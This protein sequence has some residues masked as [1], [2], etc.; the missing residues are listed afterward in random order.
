MVVKTL[1]GAKAVAEAVKNCQPDVV[2]C[3]PITPSTHIAEEMNHYYANGDT[4]TFIAVES[5]FSAISALIGGAA[6]G[7]RT[8]TATSSQGLLLMH[9]ALFNAAGMRLPIVMVVANRAVSAPL[10]IWND[11]QDSMSQRDT[12]WIQLYCKNNQE[13]VDSVI[14]AFEIAETTLLPVM[15]CIDGHYLTHAVGQV[16]IPPQSE[17]QDVL[18]PFKPKIFLDP[19]NPLSLGVYTNPSHYQEFREDLHNDLLQSK[20]KIIEIGKK[21]GKRFLRT[22]GLFEEYKLKDAEF[23]LVG[24]GSVMDNVKATVNE[25]RN[26]N[27]KVGALH[28][29]CF[30]PFPSEELKKILSGKTIGVIERDLSLGAQPPLYTEIVEAL[31]GTNTI[32]SSFFGGLGG[33]NLD[34]TA[35]KV[36]FQKIK[37]KKPLKEWIAQQKGDQK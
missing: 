29:R 15:V 4:K 24:L 10:S 21:F 8:F 23:V 28:L 26:E 34:R 33:R 14:Q 11:E 36:L 30:R 2:A 32:V 17:V 22:Y 13:A 31:Q 1:N 37:S 16:N 12:G 20:E 27:Q 35:I 9:E 7:A 19:E 25:L 3:Y 5:E 18:P 6:T